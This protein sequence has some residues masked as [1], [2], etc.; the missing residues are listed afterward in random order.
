MFGL[1]EVLKRYKVGKVLITGVNYKSK[2]YEEFKRIIKEKNIS[3]V[4][5]RAGQ[6]INLG[7]DGIIDIL[8]PQENFSGIDFPGDVNDSSV[9]ALLRFGGKKFLTMGD[10]GI[11]EEMDII[12][13]GQADIDVLKISHH[14]SR[15]STSALFLEKT[16][17]EIALVSAGARNSYGHPHKETLERLGDISFHRT[18]RQGRITVITDGKSLMV[19]TEKG[20]R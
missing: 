9:A 2:T 20:L 1:V 10:A 19:E 7:G 6:R 12:N 14:G 13:S 18:D 17:P 5:A 15:F 16:T 4:I 8:Y 3:A 11:K